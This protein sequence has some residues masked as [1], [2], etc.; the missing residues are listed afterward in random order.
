MSEPTIGQVWAA[1]DRIAEA[2][3]NDDRD[4]YVSAVEQ[5]RVLHCTDAQ[6]ADAFY[7]PIHH[8][9]S[10]SWPSFPQWV[11]RAAS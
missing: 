5:A 10:L 4:E 8:D 3:R 7:Y 9:H 2:V 11:P 1:L 6:I